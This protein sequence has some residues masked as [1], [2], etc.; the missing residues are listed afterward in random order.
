MRDT[1]SLSAWTGR[2]LLDSLEATGQLAEF[3]GEAIV[4]AVSPPYK[5]W[6]W[7]RQMR[8]MGVNSMLI[9]N[10]TALFVG[11][12]MILQ[13]GYQLQT[14]GAKNYAA[15]IGIIA[16]TREMIPVFT[17]VVVGARV[18]AA[19][20]AELGTMRVTEQIDA[21]QALAVN[22][23]KYLVA[24]RVIAGTL[25]LPIITI[26]ANIVG[27]LGG[28]LIGV[29]TLNIP[30]TFYVHQTLKFATL[31]DVVTGLIKTMVFGF[32]IAIVGCY[33]GFT[34]SGGAEGVG[35]ATTKSVVITL[36]A[37]LV[38]DYVLSSWFLVLPG[39]VG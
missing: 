8:L 22:P 4:R 37:I 35:R 36:V 20:A 17:A 13:G 33:C 21:M 10:F 15:G 34:A 9:A 7:I 26:Y 1:P 18:A 11:M 14:F 31:D 38:F 39:L 16:L 29:T 19:I 32:I 6:M 12:V 27:F 5:T 25:M 28:F 30:A 3:T 23:M 2:T 24:P